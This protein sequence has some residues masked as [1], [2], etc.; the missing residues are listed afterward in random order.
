MVFVRVRYEGKVETIPEISKMAPVKTLMK[1]I[2]EITGL[3]PKEQRLFCKGKELD[4][5][6]T[7]FDFGIDRN[8]LIEIHKRHVVAKGEDKVVDMAKEVKD[9]GSEKVEEENEENKENEAG[10][11]M[12]EKKN[13]MSASPNDKPVDLKDVYDGTLEELALCDKC[14]EEPQPN[15]KKCKKCAECTKCLDD[16]SKTCKECSCNTCG[17]KE[18]DDENL[19][20]DECEYCYHTFCLD[21][22]LDTIPEGDWY[23]P[24]CKNDKNEVV[25]PGQMLKLGRS[26]AKRPSMMNTGSRDW[27]SGMAT[28]G[29][30]KS[31]TKV[32]SNHFGPI[33]GVEVGM[34]W[35][36]RIQV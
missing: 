25:M 12:R 11:S 33:P 1:M 10:N 35:K 22:P 2:H 27:G 3:A 7:I 13:E 26:K 16:K 32:P 8:N 34:C 31:C 4:P 23:C 15:G 21:P 17:N 6:Y 29:R 9:E 5:K 28:S 20:C 14:R 36:Y 30:T 24:E 18:R 19:M